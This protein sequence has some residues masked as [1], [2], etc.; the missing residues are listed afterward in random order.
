ML[1]PVN[2]NKE[3]QDIDLLVIWGVAIATG[4]IAAAAYNATAAATAIIFAGT[5][6]A[7]SI[8]LVVGAAVLVSVLV[9]YAVG[10]LIDEYKI[11]ENLLSWLR[12]MNKVEETEEKIQAASLKSIYT[13]GM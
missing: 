11:K 8:V 10:I 9:T 6:A 3:S 4:V 5:A 13:G 1:I 7:G 2:Q 12:A